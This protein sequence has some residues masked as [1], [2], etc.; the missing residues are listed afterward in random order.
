MSERTELNSF[1]AVDTIPVLVFQNL[2][3]GT[4]EDI[5]HFLFRYPTDY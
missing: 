3:Y 5:S 1:K 4:E 2:T